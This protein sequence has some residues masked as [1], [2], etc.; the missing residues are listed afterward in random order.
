MLKGTR[1]RASSS[2]LSIRELFKEK[3]FYTVFSRSYLYIL[4]TPVSVSKREVQPEGTA[5]E[6]CGIAQYGQGGLE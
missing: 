3:S 5:C 1:R 4:K 2:N 6:G